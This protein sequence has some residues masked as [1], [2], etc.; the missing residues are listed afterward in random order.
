M[1]AMEKKKRPT[2]RGKSA[3]VSGKDVLC[4]RLCSG[5]GLGL[6]GFRAL[7]GEPGVTRET[8][9]ERERRREGKRRCV[10][11]LFALL[12][13][14]LSSFFY[15][16]RFYSFLHFAHLGPFFF[17]SEMKLVTNAVAEA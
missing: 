15:E 4:P 1:G 10:L 14:A 16:P 2:N 11:S 17:S 7:E 8:E 13:S 3:A 5:E 9:R 12:L 6:D